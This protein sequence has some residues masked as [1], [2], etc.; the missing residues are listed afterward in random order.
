[1]MVMYLKNCYPNYGFSRIEKTVLS[2]SYRFTIILYM[3]P[4]AGDH[5][6]PGI[7]E[8]RERLRKNY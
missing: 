2:P 4:F 8:F 6:L 7:K 1:M 5:L 3:N